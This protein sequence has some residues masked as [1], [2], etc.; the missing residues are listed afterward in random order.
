MRRIVFT[1]V[2]LLIS[3]GHLHA[4]DI[5]AGDS[6]TFHIPGFVYRLVAI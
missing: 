5:A 2:L 4:A 3:A 6:G 1:A